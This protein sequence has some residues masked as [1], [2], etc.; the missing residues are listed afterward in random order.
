MIGLILAF[1]AL[2]AIIIFLVYWFVFRSE[3]EEP[4]KKEVQNDCSFEGEDVF[5]KRIYALDG[6][7]VIPDEKIPCSNCSQYV[8]KTPEGC[9]P[10]GHDNEPVCVTG[11]RNTL[12][13]WSV[14][15]PKKC[16]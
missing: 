7:L 16:Q 8:Y 14:P 3:E 2:I 1:L 4:E 9:I 6:T 10:L 12:G 15:P 11:F 13:K 5:N